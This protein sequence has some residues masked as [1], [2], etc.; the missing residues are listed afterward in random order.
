MPKAYTKTKATNTEEQ[1]QDFSKLLSGVVNDSKK[2]PVKEEKKLD[3]A[4]DS[5]IKE[6]GVEVSKS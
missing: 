3:K 1:K 6:I 4:V 2:K 5:G